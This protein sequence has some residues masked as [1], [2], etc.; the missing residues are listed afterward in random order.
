MPSF[1]VKVLIS[2]T[3]S[4]PRGGLELAERSGGWDRTIEYRS[5]AV[6]DGTDP[7]YTCTSCVLPLDDPTKVLCLTT[8]RHR[9]MAEVVDLETTHGLHRY[10]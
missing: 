6:R 10:S 3:H 2:I 9:Y 5:L 1:N 8:W 7:S 4:A